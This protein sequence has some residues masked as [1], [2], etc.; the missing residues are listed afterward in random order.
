MANNYAQAVVYALA[1]GAEGRD[2]E[3]ALAG[4]L[5]R[6]PAV[7]RQMSLG[8]L[9]RDASPVNSPSGESDALASPWDLALAVEGSLLLGAGAARRFEAGG[10]ANLAAPFTFRATSAGYGSAVGGE[11]G[12]AELWLPLWSRPA[13]LSEI[14]V[15]FREARAQV[16]RRAARDGMDVA[17][18]AGELG[19]ARGVV[20]FQRFSILERAGLSNLAVPAGR[21]EVRERPGALVL[22]TLDRQGWLTR[23]LRHGAG[24]VPQAQR[25]AIGQLERASFAVA[26]TG[27]PAAVRALL[28]ALGLVERQLAMASKRSRPD[29]LRP[30]APEAARWL[31]A[32]DQTEFDV[33][34]A[35]GL[36]SVSDSGRLP[37]LREYLHGT[38]RDEHGP[39]Y[40]PERVHHAVPA[41]AGVIERLAAAHARRHQD[42]VRA[43]R[44][45]G[46]AEAGSIPLGFPAAI[47][48]AFADV[49]RFVADKSRDR[50]L[51]LLVDGMALLDFTGVP[52]VDSG[53]G[54]DTSPEPLLAILLLA[55][56]GAPRRRRSDWVAQLLALCEPR[57]DWVARLRAE[58][59]PG[60]AGEA[61]LRLRLA[62]CLPIPTAGDLNTDVVD[63]SRLAAALL[64]HLG[65]ADRRYLVTHLTLAVVPP[66]HTQREAPT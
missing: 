65:A 1:V 63:G 58:G 9:S 66:I 11:K 25:L 7:L 64:V 50:G 13:S 5:W 28:E 56:G 40:G 47:P 3:A 43:R 48:C 45:I 34:L 20:A 51:G 42:A 8:H 12:K 57:P 36:A 18:A 33:R 53:P 62:G 26:E 4:S 38:G 32:L 31:A 21:V 15:L 16:G 55:F 22:Q 27:T 44:E 52:P 2:R 37:A 35:I 23:V 49:A 24:E 54:P 10:R 14:E 39:C 59:V 60:V 41:L 17:R 61:L 19:V 46:G 30:I 6:T 29:G